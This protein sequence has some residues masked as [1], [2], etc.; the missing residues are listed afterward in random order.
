VERRR[1]QVAPPRGRRRQV[2]PPRGRRRLREYGEDEEAVRRSSV[3]L[4]LP[5]MVVVA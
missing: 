5:L 1:R 3:A 2:A 4:A